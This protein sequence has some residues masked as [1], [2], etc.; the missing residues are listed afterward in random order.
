VFLWPSGNFCV[1]VPKRMFLM[2]HALSTRSREL[3]C[4]RT[5]MLVGHEFEH[6][7]SYNE[8]QGVV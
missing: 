4:T 8:V 6:F 1:L 7:G 2:G 5:W 3:G